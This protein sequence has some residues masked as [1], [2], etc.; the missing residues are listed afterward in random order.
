M[1]CEQMQF[2]QHLAVENCEALESDTWQNHFDVCE[3][4]KA[5]WDAFS[6]SLAIFSQLERERI[7]RFTAAPSWEKFSE[8]LTADWRRW[9]FLRQIRLPATAAM[10]AA[11]A[12]G[13]AFLWFSGSGQELAQKTAADTGKQSSSASTAST[14]STARIPRSIPKI[15]PGRLN[16]VSS[17]PAGVRWGLQRSP[18]RPETY[19][20][21]FRDGEIKVGVIKLNSGAKK[22]YAGSSLGIPVV[23]PQMTRA[24][25]NPPNAT[26]VPAGTARVEYPV[27]R[28]VA[29]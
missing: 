1:S 11:L 18:A 6:R 16:Y 28:A 26:Q 3:E 19:V 9:G 5:E 20:F 27:H 17:R 23:A 12:V 7:S 21:E 4:C 13:G 10:V 25:W 15:I 22:V 24:A 14:A 8:R 29:P 2:V